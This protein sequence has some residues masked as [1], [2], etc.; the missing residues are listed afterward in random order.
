MIEP[1]WSWLLIPLSVSTLAAAGYAWGHGSV[2]RQ[3]E[4]VVA[5]VKSDAQRIAALEREVQSLRAS[6]AQQAARL[7]R[8][9]P[10]VNAAIA[11]VPPPAG[12]RGDEHEPLDPTPPEETPEQQERRVQQ[13][14]IEHFD[15]LD[16]R[17]DTELVD[18]R[19]RHETEQPLRQLMTKYLAPEITVSEA[20]CA[21]TLCRV[22]LSHPAWPHI[23]AT[24]LFEFNVARASLEVTEIQYD[25]R[26]D[27]TTTLYF[28]RG[29]APAS[30]PATPDS[31]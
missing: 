20:T 26:A 8:E 1:R 4:A 5:V 3:R 19:W 10:A 11:A 23:P 18:G 28:K 14:R 16:R 13:V 21:S 6:N 9:A 17:V 7:S 2:P 15:A 24:K 30:I 27:G 12:E 29:P 31:G 22:K 25:N